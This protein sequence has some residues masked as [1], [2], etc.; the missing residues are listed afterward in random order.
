MLLIKLIKW[1]TSFSAFND[2]PGISARG[3][4]TFEMMLID[5]LMILML[6]PLF[7]QMHHLAPL[8]VS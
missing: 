3:R 4:G 6:W 5:D 1:V 2:P 7:L 8:K